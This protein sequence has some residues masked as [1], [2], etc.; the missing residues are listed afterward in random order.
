[1]QSDQ[2]IQLIAARALGPLTPHH[3]TLA[4][5]TDLTA[6][7][8]SDTLTQQSSATQTTAAEARRRE[9]D[10]TKGSRDSD[11]DGGERAVT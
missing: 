10:T 11:V 6:R 4:H 5:L 3:S 8:H 7:N 1:M 2:H 9:E